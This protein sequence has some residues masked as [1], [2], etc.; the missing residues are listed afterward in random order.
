MAPYL[1]LPTIHV[2]YENPDWLP[3]LVAGLEAEGFT[4]E[5]HELD[6]G[7]VDPSSPPPEGIWINRISPSSHTRGHHGS[8]GLTRDFML[9]LESWGRTVINGSRAYEIEMSKLRQDMI[10]RKHGIR[11][12]RTMLVIGKEAMRKAAQTFDGPFI[13]KHNR[14]GKGLGIQLFH[15]AEHLETALEAGSLE[16]GPDGQFIL[17]EYIVSPDQFITRVEIVGGRFLFAMR[18][19]TAGGFELCPSDACQLQATGDGRPDVCPA[20]GGSDKFSS[21]PITAE[22]PLVA[23]YVSMMASEGIDLAGIEFVEDADGN[24]YTY[25]INGTTNYS[26]VLGKKIGIDG[27]R[28]VARW[29]KYEVARSYAA[30]PTRRAS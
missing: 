25:D 24:R 12:P 9:W 18:S 3:P 1:S 28:E 30:V 17:Q 19:S 4:V 22:D 13:T 23:A 15:N 11:T 14:G 10:L 21:S 26:G 8:V 27:M 20:D 6:E 5:L 7:L 2:V 16:E 29:I